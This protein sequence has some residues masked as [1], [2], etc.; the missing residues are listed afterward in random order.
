MNASVILL[1]QSVAA[2]LNE[3]HNRQSR[4]M[5]LSAWSIHYG[6]TKGCARYPQ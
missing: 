1:K 6:F 3:W 4:W 5:L 2:L